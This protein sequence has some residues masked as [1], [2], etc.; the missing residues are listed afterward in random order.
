MVSIVGHL[1]VSVLFATGS[2]EISKIIITLT[3]KQ[4][5]S[6]IFDVLR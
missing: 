5:L 6:A 2:G 3:A 1:T 4:K